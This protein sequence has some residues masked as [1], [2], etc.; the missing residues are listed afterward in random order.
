MRKI[1]FTPAGWERTS[2][3]SGSAAA[4]S[5]A[6][7]PVTVTT[8]SRRSTGRPIQI[9]LGGLT[10]IFDDTVAPGG[11]SCGG[12]L[13]PN[14]SSP[15]GSWPSSATSTGA[16]ALLV[17]ETSKSALRRPFLRCGRSD[18][19]VSMYGAIW[20]ASGADA[21]STPPEAFEYATTLRSHWRASASGPRGGCRWT[22]TS[23]SYVPPEPNGTR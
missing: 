11:I 15:S 1:P 7:S 17:T 6:S 8:S 12:R 4:R 20:S 18:V 3:P 14:C 23:C 9:C 10:R 19:V 16:L 21:A 13:K 22:S 2:A 5:A